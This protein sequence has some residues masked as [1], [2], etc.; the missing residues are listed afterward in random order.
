MFGWE[1]PPHNSGG[2]GTACEG[3][4][5]A[6]AS[7]G[8]DVI[9]V[10]PQQAPV[11]PDYMKM[12][13]ADDGTS[14]RIKIKTVDSPIYPYVTAEGYQVMRQGAP[15]SIYG[16]TL[17]D[18][19]L[20]YGQN[21]Y[22]LCSDL[23][24]DVIHAHDWLS[25]PAGIAAKAASGKPLIVHVHATE[26]DRT[27]GNGVNEHVYKIEQEGMKK[28]DCIMAVSQRTKEM[29]MKHY[30]I[31]SEKIQV[32][33]NGIDYDY[34]AFDCHNLDKLKK[35]GHKIVLFLGRITLQKGPDYFIQAAERILEYEPNT[36][37]VIAGSGDMEQQMIMS[38]AEKG[39]SHRVI[40]AGFARGAQL[41][42]LYQ[43]ADVYVMPSVS[44]PFGITPLESMA[45]LTPVVISHQSGVA[46]VVTHALKTDFWDIDDMADKIISI[47]RHDSLSRTLKEHGEHEVKQ[48][49]WKRTAAKCQ[50]CYNNITNK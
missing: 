28:A 29:L 27:G 26:F 18:E 47:L 9:F 11:S 45:N 32:V 6:L 12:V 41:Q 7:L 49:S 33:H 1:F 22:K 14:E 16:N 8:T 31:E 46:E 19:V 48:L 25:F 42:S 24:F 40:F 10:L 38:A 2:L 44:E 15:D 43:I 36:Y 39:L 50:A 5:K 13:F 34:C 23:D 35:L 21:A 37:F 30:G 4:T 3:L 20:R 17:Y